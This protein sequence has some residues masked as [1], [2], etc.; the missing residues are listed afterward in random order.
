MKEFLACQK[1]IS[2]AESFESMYGSDDG[3]RSSSSASRS[4]DKHSQAINRA[5]EDILS[6]SVRPLSLQEIMSQLSDRGFEISGKNPSRNVGSRLSHHD[7]FISVGR[8]QWVLKGKEAN[9]FND[10]RL[11]DVKKNSVESYQDPPF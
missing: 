10:G 11:D 7:Q 8:D 2:A 1:L 9:G 3:S 5:I 6:R 4:S